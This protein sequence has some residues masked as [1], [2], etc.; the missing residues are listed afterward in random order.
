M[1][2]KTRKEILQLNG[3]TILVAM[4]LVG[5]L[6]IVGL[7]FRF[8][9]YKLFTFEK[10]RQTQYTELLKKEHDIKEEVAHLEGVSA[11]NDTTYVRLRG[12]VGNNIR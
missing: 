10:D 5:D 12:G 1:E 4:V 11:W 2:T 8:H 9:Q 3:L 6:L 7:V